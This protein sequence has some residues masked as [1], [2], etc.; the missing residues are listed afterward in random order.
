VLIVKE[1]HDGPDP[2]RTAEQVDQS[3]LGDIALYSARLIT[4]DHH[5]SR[6]RTLGD[7]EIGQRLFQGASRVGFDYPDLTWS[8]LIW[9]DLTWSDLAR[10]DLAGHALIGHAQRGAFRKRS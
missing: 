4:G 7:Q 3:L 8:D 2:E 1:W 6:L 10:L 5:H 9:S